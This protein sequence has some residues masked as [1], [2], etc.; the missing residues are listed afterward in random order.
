MK[1]F[2]QYVEESIKLY[3]GSLYRALHKDVGK[4]NLV[5]HT[6]VLKRIMELRR[7]GTSDKE[8][9]KHYGN[10]F[11]DG[12]PYTNLVVRDTLARFKEHLG[13]DWVEPKY[14]Q[15]GTYRPKG[16]EGPKDSEGLTHAVVGMHILH[17]HTYGSI[18]HHLSA[19]GDVPGINRSIVA[20]I[21]NRAKKS[22]IQEILSS[23]QSGKGHPLYQKYKDKPPL[24]LIRRKNPF[25]EKGV[26]TEKK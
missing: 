26:R 17:G 14:K 25:A 12:K 11:N 24:D 16:E 2:K 1:S 13:Q 21:I 3:Q 6:F 22:N 9:G 20:G 19:E 10:I 15:K 18:A 8:I 7:L 23:I 5:P 4:G